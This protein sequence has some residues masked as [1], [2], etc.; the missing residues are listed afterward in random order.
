VELSTTLEAISCT[1]TRFPSISWNPKI[2]YRVY[3]SS[4][5]VPILSLTTPVH[6]TLIYLY[7][8]HLSIIHPPTCEFL[9]GLNGLLPSG[10]PINNL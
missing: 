2:H 1:V 3:K 4:S 5:T 6:T 8:I 9:N 10:V 7:N